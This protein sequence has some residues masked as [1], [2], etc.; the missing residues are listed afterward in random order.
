MVLSDAV[1]AVVAVIRRRPADILPWYLLGAAVPAVARVIPFLAFAIGFVYLEVTGRLAAAREALTGLETDPPDPDADPEAF[2]AWATG[3]EPVVEQLFTPGLVLLVAMTIVATLL[4][5]VIL[6]AAVTAGQLTA[7]DSRLRN[8][9]GLT[10]GLAGARHYWLRFLGLYVLEFLLW[11]AVL[12]TVGLGVA[13]VAGIVAVAT[14]SMLIAG[15]VALFA[16]FVLV[17]ALAV[18]RAL[19]AFA[20]VSVVVDD[21]TVVGSLSNTVSFVRARPVRAGFYYVVSIGTIIAFSVISGVFSLVDVVAFPSLLTVLLVFPALDLLKTALYS[22][23]RGRLTPPSMPERSLRRQFRD[24]VRRGWAELTAFVR[25]TLGTHALVV[26][27]AV[28]SFWVGWEFSEPLVGS[29]ETSISA[30]LEGHIAP[31]AALEFFGN[32]WLV[33]LT[34][35]LSGLVLV[36]PA[37]VSL[38]FNGLVMGVYA[39]TEVAPMEL[40]AF[41]VPHG[42]LEIPAIFIATALGV[43]L[44]L[45]GW[46]TARGQASRAALADTLERAFWVLVGVGILL[47]IA[48]VIEGFVSPY[49]FRLFL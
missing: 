26:A 42:I 24:G 5:G 33:A 15:V 12:L 41:V 20:P 7:C 48:A 40:L 22:G 9:R 27:L 10:A 28:G 46:R 8:E 49:Y 16:G 6:Y 36:I 32:N 37:I 14:G 29:F 4:V 45:A 1:S 31:A 11:L 47:A 44:G 3:F 38:L 34:T 35:A 25:A 2:E 21:A 13:F 19:F 43:H 18:V 17:A 39:R 23:Y 30:R